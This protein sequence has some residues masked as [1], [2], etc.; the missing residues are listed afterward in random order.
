MCATEVRKSAEMMVGQQIVTQRIKAFHLSVCFRLFFMR[1]P[2]ANPM[3][4]EPMRTT[5]RISVCIIAQYDEK[6]DEKKEE[7][8]DIC[9]LR[10]QNRSH[11]SL[12]G[13]ESL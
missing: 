9:G 7:F 13:I 6:H 4:T 5:R 11:S 12:G 2:M 3:R 10:K 1:I 8:A